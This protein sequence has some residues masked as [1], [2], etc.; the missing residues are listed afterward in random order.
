MS[1]VPLPNGLAEHA[2]LGDAPMADHDDIPPPALSPAPSDPQPHIRASPSGQL[3]I[4]NAPPSPQP[5]KG[6][7]VP[8]DKAESNQGALVQSGGPQGTLWLLCKK[9][10]FRVDWVSETGEP[11]ELVL[12]EASRNVLSVVVQVDHSPAGNGSLASVILTCRPMAGSPSPDNRIYQLTVSTTHENYQYFEL[13]AIKTILRGWQQDSHGATTAAISPEVATSPNDHPAPPKPEGYDPSDSSTWVAPFPP[14][15]PRPASTLAGDGAPPA[16]RAKPSKPREPSIG[17]YPPVQP[18][19]AAGGSAAEPEP[20]YVEGEPVYSNTGR[21]RRRSTFAVKSYAIPSGETTA[22]EESGAEEAAG[23][24]GSRSPPKTRRKSPGASLAGGSPAL[25]GSLP[26]PSASAAAPP[27]QI[28]LGALPPLPST[29]GTGGTPGPSPAVMNGAS[30]PAA[31]IQALHTQMQQLF[32]YV[33]RLAHLVQAQQPSAAQGAPADVSR[34]LEA[35]RA[36][37]E[38][39]EQEN[40]SFKSGKEAVEAEVQ[41]LRE[42]VEGSV[43]PEAPPAA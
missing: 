32:Q 12:R 15:A 25:S 5:E 30:N 41:R 28:Q 27:P 40:A 6:A 11:G 16:K 29:T 37:C 10:G 17:P 42:R 7:K 3:Y 4:G 19:P 20:V 8:L 39:L 35:L 2:G 33:G 22:A 31:Q 23:G 34:E 18:E 21:E 26:L 9:G 36:R 1:V 24:R 14:P 43:A 38:K 13:E